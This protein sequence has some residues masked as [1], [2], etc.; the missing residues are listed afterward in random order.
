MLGKLIILAGAG[1]AAYRLMP[2]QVFDYAVRFQ[3]WRSGLELKETYVDDHRVP[4]LEGGRG[5]TLLLLHGFGADKDHWTAIA[6]FLTPHFHVIAPDLPG[7]GDSSRLDDKRYDLSSQLSRIAQFAS[8]LG[9]ARFHLGG[10][11]MGGYLAGMY[12]ADHPEQV[13]T[14]WLLAPAGVAGATPSELFRLIE[15]GQNLLF[16]DSEVTAKRLTHLLFTKAPFVPEEFN[17]VWR[18]RVMRNRP[19]NEKIFG[20][21]FSAPTSFEA[22]LQSVSLATPALIVWGDDDRLLDVTGAPILAGLL[23]NAA[24]R[25]MRAM[26]HCPMLE[27]PRETAADLL[28]FHRRAIE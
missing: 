7:F 4:Y 23:P 13:S 15:T 6:Q 10:N 2:E 9:L 3:R 22:R 27:R 8:Q 24:L 12:A 17:R 14:L 19:F 28:N 25:I 11:S 18:Q 26:G 20:E 1:Y 5:E 16:V 21:L